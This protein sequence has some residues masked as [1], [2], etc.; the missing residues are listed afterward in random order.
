MSVERVDVDETEGVDLGA[1]GGTQAQ[2][3]G[4][5]GE[6]GELAPR[7]GLRPRDSD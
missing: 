6:S 4:Q 2:E 1:D 3:E 5:G 7:L